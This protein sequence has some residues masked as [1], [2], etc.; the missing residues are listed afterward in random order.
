MTASR[1]EPDA[2][3]EPASAGTRVRLGTMLALVMGALV[4]LVLL[5][6]ILKERRPPH[7]LAFI[8]PGIAPAV[9]AAVW[10]TSRIRRYRVTGGELRVELPLRTVRFP[11]AGLVSAVPDRTA[12]RGAR[13]IAGNDGLG[14]VT[15][16]F[17]SRQLGRFRAYLTDVEHAV[18]LRWPDRCL[19][20]SPQHHSLF[21]E[22]V[23]RRA[24]LPR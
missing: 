3:F 14:A 18:V 5:V 1:Y 13:K 6:V 4:P 8:A 20:I 9:L 16:R 17:R 11:L 23:R 19:V 7:W 10:S 21:V 12:L 15:G 2:V 24:G 22:A